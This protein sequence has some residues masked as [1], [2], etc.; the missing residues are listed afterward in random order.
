M[1]IGVIFLHDQESDDALKIPAIVLVLI[2]L[3]ND[4][5]TLSIAYDKVIP[6][7]RPEMWYMVRLVIIAIS[8]GLVG[9]VECY[10]VYYFATQ[11][12]FLFSPEQFPFFNPA[13][14]LAA[15]LPAGTSPCDSKYYD[16]TDSNFKSGIL[17]PAGMTFCQQ[18]VQQLR[19]FV[20]AV[21]AVS[22][23]CTYL[24]I[25]SWSQ[26]VCTWLWL[27]VVSSLCMCAVPTAS[28]SPAALVTCC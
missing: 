24:F 25:F 26:A 2:T 5:T 23:L 28:S 19:C 20:L 10:L 9:V 7:Q 17:N 6:S 15:P 21:A 8:V 4:G 3:V 22:C 1:F 16:S 18:S 11:R 12:V 13:L 27:L 14:Y